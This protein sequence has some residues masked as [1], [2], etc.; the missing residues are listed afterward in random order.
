MTLPDQRCDEQVRLDKWLWAARFFKTRA[1]ATCAVNAAKVELNGLNPKPSKAV[2]VGDTITVNRGEYSQT[3]LV[4]AVS[5]KRGSAKL[6]GAL[7]RETSASSDLRR[8][9]QHNKMRHADI[10]VNKGKLN[11]KER[12]IALRIKHD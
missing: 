12:R 8:L 6:A 9:Q 10:Q 7:Y 4:L 3:V 5:A 11:K 2:H 1:M